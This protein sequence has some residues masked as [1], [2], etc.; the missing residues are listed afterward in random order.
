MGSKIEGRLGTVREVSDSWQDG[1]Y[2][3][4]F[5][6]E[7][8]PD[9]SDGRTLAILREGKL[10]GSDEHG[11]VFEGLFAATLCGSAACIAVTLRVP[12]GGVLITGDRSGCEEAVVDIVGVLLKTGSDLQGICDICGHQMAVRFRYV[13]SLPH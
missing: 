13:G 7:G 6:Q 12:A 9:E 10:L 2:S 5:I 4:A 1:L 8:Q 11:G 3:V